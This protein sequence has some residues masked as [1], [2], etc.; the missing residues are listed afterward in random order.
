MSDRKTGTVVAPQ[1]IAAD[2]SANVS[3]DPM[4]SSPA[5]PRRPELEPMW[6]V[7]RRLPK[8]AR[9]SAAIARDQRVPGSA[10]TILAVGGLYLVSPIDLVPGIIPVAGQLD[11]LYVVLTALRQA[12]RMSPDDAIDEHLTAVDLDRAHID[13]DLAAIRN[14]VRRGVIWSLYKS[15]QVLGRGA[16]QA[17]ALA[18]RVRQHGERQNDQ[19]PHEPR[20][21]STQPQPTARRPG[22]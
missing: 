1:G 12:I 7:I 15:G 20:T 2:S 21:S 5:G 6:R 4:R 9:L 10:K 3:D 19:E 8:Y 14:F 16:R 13:D 11:D 22:P 18:Q 17:I